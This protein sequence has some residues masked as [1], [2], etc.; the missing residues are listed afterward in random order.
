MLFI[1]VLTTVALSASLTIAVP[2]SGHV[3]PALE[4]RH[5]NSCGYND[6]W[7]S[8]KNCC[9][10]NG[11]DSPGTPGYVH[12]LFRMSKRALNVTTERANPAP[13]TIIGTRSKSTYP[14]A[15]QRPP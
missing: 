7:Y 12:F 8:K 11:G 13:R 4:A 2:S 14:D 5:G 1:S 10:K 15:I 3:E 6:F 9:V